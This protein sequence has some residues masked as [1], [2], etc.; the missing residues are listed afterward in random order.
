MF[1]IFVSFLFVSV[2]HHSYLNHW[3][4]KNERSKSV[5]LDQ[6][7]TERRDVSLALAQ[8]GRVCV[9]RVS[10]E[11]EFMVM[12]NGRTEHELSIGQPLQLDRFT[13]CLERPQIALPHPAPHRP[14]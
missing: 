7:L 3:L 13:P 14:P 9:Y 12:R 5:F 6:P 2:L 1:F 10:A 4:I 11:H 8:C